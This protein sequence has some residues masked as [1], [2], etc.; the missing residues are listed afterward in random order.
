M[1]FLTAILVISWL[2]LENVQTP[3]IDDDYSL[4]LGYKIS[5]IDTQVVF[6][7]LK[8]QY[9]NWN[10]RFGESLSILGDVVGQREYNVANA[11][12]TFLFFLL[13]I[14]YG[15][16]RAPTGLGAQDATMLAGTA[17]LFMAGLPDP[18]E[19]FFWR[20]G[21]T[22]YLWALTFLLLYLVPFH[23]LLKGNDV[24]AIGNS[25]LRKLLSLPTVGFYVG[26]GI[27]IGHANENAS[28]TAVLFMLVVLLYLI[29]KGRFIWWP[30]WATISM[31]AGTFM[32]LFAHSTAHRMA[33]YAKVYGVSPSK[34]VL[35]VNNTPHTLLM[36]LRHGSAPLLLLGVLLPIAVKKNVPK[37]TLLY[38]VGCV[39]FSVGSALILAAAPYQHPRGLF[40]PYTLL[41]V[42]VL[43]L[44]ANLDKKVTAISAG[45]VIVFLAVTAPKIVSIHDAFIERRMEAARRQQAILSQLQGAGEIIVPPFTVSNRYAYVGFPDTDRYYFYYGIDRCRKITEAGVG[46]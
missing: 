9:T 26:A 24:F 30:V 37:T 43:T 10:A 34:A 33:Y 22:N 25:R 42:T 46:H 31:T 15:A 4:S 27:I 44:F 1:F 3:K 32:L 45:I 41:V 19:I 12:V 2:L 5:H 40:L 36:W 14:Y 28:P 18:G 38:G 8:N 13:V 11:L 7:R 35:F 23:Q 20:S 29:Q 6:A 17:V 16:G 21:A 39:I